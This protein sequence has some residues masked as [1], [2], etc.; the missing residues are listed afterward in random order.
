[1][2]YNEH[3]HLNYNKPRDVSFSNHMK[4]NIT[5]VSVISTMEDSYARGRT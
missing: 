5:N 4:I 1:M 2:I 3:L